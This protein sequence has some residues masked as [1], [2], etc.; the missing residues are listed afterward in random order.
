MAATPSRASI[1]HHLR[2]GKSADFAWQIVSRPEILHLWFPGITVCVV[3]G[4]TRV[5]TLGS[6]M[7]MPETILTNDALQKRF[8]YRITSPVFKEHLATIDVVAL[9][10]DVCLV[11]YST[12]ADPAAMALMIGGA[13]L[14]ALEELKR[15]C[16][17]NHGPAI[18]AVSAH[19]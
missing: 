13:T 10:D 11:M 16:E 6:G 18:E 17:A 15:Q 3:D 12:D 7:T 9:D 4:D 5:I 1:R 19:K 14:G 8:Q 2:I